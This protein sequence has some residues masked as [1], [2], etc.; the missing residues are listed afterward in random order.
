M[1]RQLTTEDT[2]D[3]EEIGR[4]VIACLFGYAKDKPSRASLDP[5]A[6]LRAG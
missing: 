4:M 2:G 6:A 3:A 1:E 5:S